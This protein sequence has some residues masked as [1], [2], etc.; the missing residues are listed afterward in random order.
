MFV[1]KFQTMFKRSETIRKPIFGLAVKYLIYFILA[2]ALCAT[3]ICIFGY[4]PYKRGFHDNL[5]VIVF[6][7]LTGGG[8]FWWSRILHKFSG[9]QVVIT[10]LASYHE[11]FRIDFVQILFIGL[12]CVYFFIE[13]WPDYRYDFY[14]LMFIMASYAYPLGLKLP[15]KIIGKLSEPA[16]ETNTG[17]DKCR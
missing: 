9:K 7:F 11:R 3:F 4:D 1:E 17:T 5:W 14:S 13:A 6:A 12:V 15:R 2:Y 10:G 16:S 8:I